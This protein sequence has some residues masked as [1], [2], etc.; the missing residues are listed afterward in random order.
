MAHLLRDLTQNDE[1][2][3]NILIEEGKDIIV[4]RFSIEAHSS[5]RDPFFF[6]EDFFG[7][8]IIYILGLC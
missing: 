2:G 7:N 1:E 8:M 4:F 5:L 3:T 6:N